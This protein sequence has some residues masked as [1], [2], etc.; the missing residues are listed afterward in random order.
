M[1]I[2]QF[3][4]IG[5]SATAMACSSSTSSSGTGTTADSTASADVSTGND[6]GSST[7]TDTTV[8]SDTGGSGTDATAS[9]NPNANLAWIKTNIVTPTCSVSGCHDAANADISGKLAMDGDLYSALVNVPV[10]DAKS[11]GWLRV[12]PGNVDKSFMYQVLLKKVGGTFPMP[13]AK[14]ALT[15]DQL[16]AVHDWIMAGAPK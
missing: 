4:L 13:M 5:L 3:L 1:R 15:A 9:T 14:P 10:G 2:D 12:V 6:T 16:A 7:G 11:A 8:A